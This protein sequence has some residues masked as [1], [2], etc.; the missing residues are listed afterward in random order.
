MQEINHIKVKV[1]IIEER[2]LKAIIGLDYG[3]HVVKGF[4]VFES[5]YLNSRGEKLWL[6]PPSYKDLNDS[7]HPI[8]FMPDKD[9]WRQLEDRILD[10]YQRRQKEYYKK[11]YGIE[12]EEI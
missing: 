7:Y 4:R 10:E 3:N 2:K 9:A 8:F 11:K 5:E 1:K 12:D 6:V